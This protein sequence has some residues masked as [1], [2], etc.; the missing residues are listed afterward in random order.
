MEYLNDNIKFND[1]PNDAILYI[2]KMYNSPNYNDI[3]IINQV[4]NYISQEQQKI[5]QL[6]NNID[7]HND[8][9]IEYTKKIKD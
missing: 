7:T 8:K 2:H 4:Y 3:N 5:I 1:I 6:Q 9:I